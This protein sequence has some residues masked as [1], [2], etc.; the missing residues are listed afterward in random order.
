[1]FLDVAREREPAIYEL[2][3]KKIGFREV[4]YCIWFSIKKL[5]LVP[6][7]LMWLSLKILAFC[8]FSTKTRN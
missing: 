3:M 4:D 7:G 5:G 6:R 2:S 8:L 1:L